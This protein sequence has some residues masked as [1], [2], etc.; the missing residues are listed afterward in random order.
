MKRY[1][2]QVRPIRN[3]SKTV[4]MT[5]NNEW[6]YVNRYSS[7]MTNTAKTAMAIGYIQSFLL[8]KAADKDEFD[9]AVSQQICCSEKDGIGRKGM[10]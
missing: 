4:R 5:R 10:V 8:K 7:Y 9:D 1:S 6:V 3:K 2:C